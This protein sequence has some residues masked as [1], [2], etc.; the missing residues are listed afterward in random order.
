MLIILAVLL[1]FAL[2]F[3]F[4]FRDP[5]TPEVRLAENPVTEN[6]EGAPYN[7][8]SLIEI[9]PDN[10][11]KVLATLERTEA[12]TRTIR[13]THYWS[14]GASSAAR[15]A[16]IWITPRALRI[17]WDDGEN[18]ILTETAY[19][20]WFDDRP[21]HSR[22]VTAGLGL[23]LEQILNE[24]QG[25]PSYETVLELDPN[26]ILEA[27]Y[28]LKNIGGV[29]E[30]CVYFV[31]GDSA[32]GYVDRYYISLNSGLLIAMLTLDGDIP[33]FR[34]ETLR[35]T[36]EPPAADVFVLHVLDR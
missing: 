29:Y 21:P 13:Q 34:M 25:I 32:L 20:I 5:E 24:F 8:A 33:V 17:A 6:G 14:E 31:F 28:V 36:L 18:V 26:Q 7:P 23:S 30:Y 12:Y 1:V 35:L 19:H 4:F 9:T 15:E 22:P 3:L 27:G 16:E 10:V 11:Q 2:L